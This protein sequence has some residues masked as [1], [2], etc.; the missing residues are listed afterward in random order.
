MKGPIKLVRSHKVPGYKNIESL[1]E[2]HE[3]KAYLII[4]KVSFKAKVGA[5]LCY[6]NPPLHL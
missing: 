3:G 5:I 2:W 6:Y 4:D 1:Y